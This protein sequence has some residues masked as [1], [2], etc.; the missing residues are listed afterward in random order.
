M[1]SYEFRCRA[2]GSTFVESRPAAAC[3]DLARD[4]FGVTRL[5]AIVNPDNEASRMVAERIGLRPEKS[6][7][8]FGR[9]QLILAATL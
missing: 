8:V 4:R 5:I 2:D 3:R 7:D 6:T 9:R 1:P